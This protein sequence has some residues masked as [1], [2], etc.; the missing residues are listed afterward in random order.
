M[1]WP[2]LWWKRRA[3]FERDLADE[4]AFHLEARAEDLARSGI[5]ALDARRRARL[6]FGGLDRW[7]EACRE[8]RPFRPLDE[9]RADLRYGLRALRKSPAFTFVAVFSLAIGIG[10]NTAIFSLIDGLWLRPMAAGGGGEIV[11]LFTTSPENRQGL[12]SWDEY[13]QIQTQ[14]R[15]F[16][17]AVAIGSR[18]VRMARPDG[19]LELT[20]INV[21]STDFFDTLGIHPALGRLFSA[22][23]EPAL[24]A[25]P[26]VVLG[27]SF[28]QR[29]FG[30]D[31]SI[32]GRQIRLEHTGDHLVT[33]AGILSG[34]FRA[35]DADGD[36]DLWMPPQTY[37]ALGGAA[38]FDTHSF[39]WF[40]LLARM[41][42]GIPVR[43]AGAEAA[44]IAARWAA[45]WPDTNRGRGVSVISDLEYRMRAAGTTAL[46][47][48]G[49]VLL[50]AILSAVNVANLLLARAAARV[51][52]FSIR[53]AIGAG[54]ARIARQMLTESALLGA[55]GLAAGILLGYAIVVLLPS[56]LGSPPGYH[57]TARF[58]LDSRVF[59]FGAL[60]AAATTLLF[61][62]V[63]SFS[64]SRT[65]LNAHLTERSSGGPRAR[66]GAR[67]WL[68][69]A[70]VAMA[71][72]LVSLA[73]VLVAS[74]VR[75]RSADLGMARCELLL[76]WCAD[77][78]SGPAVREAIERLRALPGVEDV[79][80]AIRAPLSPEEQGTAQRVAFPGRPEKP[81]AAPLEIFYNAIS[82]NY[83]DVTGIAVVRGRGF[84]EAD[85]TTGPPVALISETM[86][87]RYWPGQDAVGKTIRIGDPPGTEHRIVGV[88]RDVP[89]NNL[90]DPP[91][92]YLYLPWWRADPGEVTFVIHT[93][94]RAATL[95]AA[96]RQ[97]L[98]AID[99]RLDPFTIAT[100]AELIRYSALQYELTAELLSILGAIALA[101]TAIGLY[102]VVAWSVT[103]RTREIGIRMALGATP[104]QA[105]ALV[106]RQTA[107]IGTVG[108]AFG[109]PMA[110]AATRLARSLLYG[111]VPWDP[112]LLALALA[113]LAAALLLA[114]FLPARRATAIDPMRA[115]RAE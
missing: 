2:K 34:D 55:A 22:G 70:Q 58:Q 85:Q 61:G 69:A 23:D 18:G 93:R 68:I 26:V 13:R 9:L 86:A 37:A 50:V 11:R 92:P 7:K 83:L 17:T 56:I 99:R 44:T 6:E 64:A 113:V 63:P 75:T 71:L 84:S 46:V 81:G 49:V 89:F 90:S 14:A 60:L 41:R 28:W 91:L 112:M 65:A 104:R 74:F 100:E 96:A 107:A 82:S 21:V 45:A 1:R 12:F 15:T 57:S 95:A 24:A 31:P 76:E 98:I 78:G 30:G 27:Q 47:L 115:L 94:Q 102:G 42:P 20:S 80:L 16:S 66:L 36:R 8:T 3:A 25:R 52:E 54:R 101:L 72:T 10:V 53:L 87:A 62:L 67:Q 114:G 32:V 51:R 29:R 108:L 43:S 40:R 4:L 79:A 109:L 5:P 73:A 103:R 77:S 110:L 105:L 59:L 39:R 97:T 88:V 35:I 111:T 38:D 19:T 33:V 48:A 106:L